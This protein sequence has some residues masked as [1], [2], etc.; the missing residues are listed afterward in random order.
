MALVQQATAPQSA[1]P[2]PA[3]HYD[4]VEEER[5][6]AKENSPN[7]VLL[8][9]GQHKFA[10]AEGFTL[11][12]ALHGLGDSAANF[13][14]NWM[15]LVD[16]RPDVVVALPEFT[17]YSTTVPVITEMIDDT[18]AHYHVNP[19]RVFLAGYSLGGGD[20]SVI[21]GARPDLFA[22][23]A[24]IS[25]MDARFLSSAMKKNAGKMA[26]YISVG[27]KEDS[28]VEG[29]AFGI[30]VL[31]DFGFTHVYI[32]RRDGG[33]AIPR[34]IFEQLTKNMMT[35]FDSVLAAN[36]AQER[37]EADTMSLLAKS[38]VMEQRTLPQ[39]QGTYIFL[40]PDRKKFPATKATTLLIGLHGNGDNAANFA[41][42][43]TDLVMSRTDVV[44]AVPEAT[45]STPGKVWGPGA[46]DLVTAI[47]AD[48]V[49]RDHVNP[50]QVILAGS[51]TGGTAGGGIMGEHPDLFSG[52]AA[53]GASLPDTFFTPALRKNAANLAVYYA[54]STTQDDFPE[55]V[56]PVI[57]RLQNFGFE[58]H[59]YPP[60]FHQKWEFYGLEQSEPLPPPDFFPANFLIERFDAAQGLTPDEF[61]YRITRMMHFFDQVEADRQRKAMAATTPVVET[62]TLAKP[63]EAY[64]LLKSDQGGWPTG[65]GA[66]LLICLHGGGD[67]ADSIAK[68]W[69]N[70]VQYCPAFMVAVPE[71]EPVS[72]GA[73]AGGGG[74]G[75]TDLVA[76]IIADTVAHDRVNPRQVILAG[77][78]L[79]GGRAAGTVA[80]ERPDLF[81]GFAAL[82]TP[83]PDGFFTAAVKKNAGKMAVYYETGTQDED[84]N[85]ADL[86]AAKARLKDFGFTQLTGPSK[87]F[88]ET[89]NL[90]VITPNHFNSLTIDEFNEYI[91]T[92]MGFFYS[93]W[94][95]NNQPATAVAENK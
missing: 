20:G 68:Y 59:P 92:M 94:A 10:P 3:P 16:S 80:G 85:P 50:Q 40:T 25:G 74:P 11:V 45:Q 70:L 24:G 93:G 44:V 72:E 95:T 14:K 33:H 5:P 1:T 67:P 22:G 7:Y 55:V 17:A 29:A 62:R 87:K 36:K 82:A 58:Y 71:A 64:L 23:F 30:S 56:N 73:Q 77:Y 81:A 89:G 66:T 51:G 47:I 32:D 18:V 38:M 83:F 31:K 52:F 75:D 8:T 63:E 26:L 48:T 65:K 46:S 61:K 28:S 60:D 90:R 43:W 19:R 4:V 76:A 91:P 53:F 84:Y 21:V 79:E 15:A 54:Y 9:P 88:S 35:F 57:S 69:M 12:I 78:G 27:T 37:A 49:A 13:A 2:A 41:K 39:A 42:N 34:P 6:L 86:A